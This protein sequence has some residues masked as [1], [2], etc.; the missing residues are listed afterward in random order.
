MGSAGN[1]RDCWPGGMR[2]LALLSVRP[3]LLPG[4][5]FVEGVCH[6]ASRAGPCDKPS[7][8]RAGRRTRITCSSGT[9][10]DSQPPDK[11]AYAPIAAS[12]FSAGFTLGPLLDGL[13]GRVGLLTYDALPLDVG[14]LH[15]SLVVP[16]L[17]ATFYVVLGALTMALDSAAGGGAKDAVERCSSAGY[18]AL[19]LGSVAALLQLS[20]VLYRLGFAYSTIG[21]VLAAAGAA[22]WA[23]F[24][25]TKHGVALC[26]LCAVA[27]PLS[28]LVIVRYLGWWHYNAP[29]VYG[30][31][32]LPSWVPWCYF[33]YAPLV[34]NLARLLRLR[35]SY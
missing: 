30:A 29:D 18:V 16:P 15:S 12:L 10:A 21:A 33:F 34:L 3:G 19:S 6:A 32:G 20:A 23:V 5:V 11:V 24:D 25:R 26:A 8:L 13:H 14:D 35:F 22:N 7:A 9:P 1:N 27:A 17:L 28:E 31:D 2:A 4:R